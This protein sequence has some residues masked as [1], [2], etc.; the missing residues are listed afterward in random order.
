MFKELAMI[1]LNNFYERSKSEL[2]NFLALM[3][4]GQNKDIKKDYIGQFLS[5]EATNDFQKKLR[6]RI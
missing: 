4:K 1:H 3:E 2:K 5:P 6:H